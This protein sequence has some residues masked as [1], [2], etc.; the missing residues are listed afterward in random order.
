MTPSRLVQVQRRF[1]R[2]RFRRALAEYGTALVFTPAGNGM[3]PARVK[4][5]GG[6]QAP[7]PMGRE[8]REEIYLVQSGRPTPRQRRRLAH[9]SNHAKRREALA[10]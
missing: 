4:R 10:Q 9:K 5:H 3:A 7:S 6:V 2:S 1:G 8:R